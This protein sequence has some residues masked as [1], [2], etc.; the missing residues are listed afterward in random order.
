MEGENAILHMET[1]ETLVVCGKSVR[2]GTLLI[3]PY[4]VQSQKVL[5]LVATT[6]C[7]FTTAVK[8]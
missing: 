2:Y 3:L 8:P 4:L 6:A 5:V 7:S 1:E